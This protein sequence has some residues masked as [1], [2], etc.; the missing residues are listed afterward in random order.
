MIYLFLVLNFLE[1]IRT[2]NYVRR[3]F[4]SAGH[5]TCMSSVQQLVESRTGMYELVSSYG[6]SCYSMC[7]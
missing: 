7:W 3:L 2:L 5:S 1:R 4:W 6:Y